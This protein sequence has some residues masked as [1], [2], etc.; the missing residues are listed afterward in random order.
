[1]SLYKL[2]QSGVIRGALNIP[3][4]RLNADWQQYQLWL[5]AGN[6]PDPADPLPLRSPDLVDAD[7]AKAIAAVVALRNMTPS[8]A[9]AW[10]VANVNTLADAKSLLGT[11]AAVLCVLARR[12]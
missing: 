11:M 5:A 3:A 12:L 9:T 7:A 6:A 4:D 8:Q 10:V 2:T 1:M